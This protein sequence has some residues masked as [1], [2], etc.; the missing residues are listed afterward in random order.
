MSSTNKKE[1]V[2]LK[3]KHFIV[4]QVGNKEVWEFN[5]ER[6]EKDVLKVTSSK[7]KKSK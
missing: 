5:W 6:L 3:N 4:K 1:K 7:K 2:L